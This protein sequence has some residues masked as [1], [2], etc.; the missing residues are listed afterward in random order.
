MHTKRKE[1]KKKAEEELA[2]L[3]ASSRP[4]KGIPSNKSVEPMDQVI[5]AAM[6][7]SPGIDNEE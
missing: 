5:L 7:I 1:K 3:V 4:K 6:T 2:A